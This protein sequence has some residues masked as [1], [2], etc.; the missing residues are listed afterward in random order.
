MHLELFTLR[1]KFSTII[2]MIIFFKTT[3]ENHIITVKHDWYIKCVIATEQKPISACCV[4]YACSLFAKPYANKIPRYLHMW[5]ENSAGGG[6]KCH[7]LWVS[8]DAWGNYRCRI[9][10]HTGVIALALNAAGSLDTQRNFSF[11]VCVLFFSS[12]LGG[13]QNKLLFRVSYTY[14]QFWEVICVGVYMALQ[15]KFQAF[16]EENYHRN[17]DSKTMIMFSRT[18]SFWK[19]SKSQL[20]ITK[21]HQIVVFHK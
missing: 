9:I 19:I 7:G 17:C 6:W 10:S 20:Y 14:F 18:L 4:E 12:V 16:L 1:S 13:N 5:I 15:T 3:A 2:H 8:L 11:N 21:S